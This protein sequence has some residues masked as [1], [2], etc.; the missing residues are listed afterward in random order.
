MLRPPDLRT[1]PAS[2]LGD[3]EGVLAELL[4]DLEPPPHLWP[5]PGRPPVLPALCLW[6]GML[7]CV[8]RGFSSQLAIWRLV[9]QTGLWDYARLQ[10]S[11]QA[12]YHRLARDGTAPLQQLF[13]Q[14]THL[15]D[16]RLEPLLPAL[17]PPLAAFARDIVVVDETTLDAVARRLPAEPTQ[18]VGSTVLGGKLAGVFDV[19][20]QCWRVLQYHVNPVQNERVAARSLVAELLPGTLVLFDLGYFGFAWLDHLTEQGQWWVT[21]MRAKT[22]YTPIHI[23]SQTADSLDA[24]IWLGAH[25]ADRAA[26]PVRMVEVRHGQQTRRYLTNVR[27]PDQLSLG[28][29]LDLYARRWDIEMAIQLVKQHLGLR[30]LWSCKPVVIEQQVWAVLIIAQIVQALRLEIAA[31]AGVSVFEVSLPLIVQYLPEFARR[32]EDP[33]AAMVERG[34]AAGFIRPSRRIQIHSPDPPLAVAWS[35]GPIPLSRTPRYAGK[36]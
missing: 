16:A 29:V 8:L 20:R 3:V 10:I 17:L 25:R 13:A 4:Q 7:V 19:R 26:Y 2:L 27:D 35:V 31:R 15:L 32:G 6:G 22:S 36:Q 33:V 5:L 9:T 28:E 1:D 12:I 34:R 23:F 18:T 30:L 14:I 21:R 11:E 24:L